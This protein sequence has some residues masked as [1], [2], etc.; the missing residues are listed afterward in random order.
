VL[1]KQATMLDIITGGRFILGVGAGWHVG[2]HEA[3]GIELPQPRE[4]F[5]RYASALRVVSALFS[6]AARQSPGV[7]LDDPIYSLDRATNEPPPTTS[8]GPPIWLGGQRRRGIELIARYASGWP[9]PG[10]Q[11][12]DV[13]YF[14]EKRDKIRRALEAAGRDPQDFTFAAQVDC[15]AD[16][17]ARRAALDVARQMQRAGAD[18]VILGI[19][20]AAAPDTLVAM[21]REVAQPLRESGA[22]W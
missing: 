22:R 1:A 15:G 21:A 3:F 11:A 20:G 4:R 12:G 17:N 18:H 5:D 6:E 8:T 10:N 7:T 2:E 14:I 16:D 9:L 13:A 19:P